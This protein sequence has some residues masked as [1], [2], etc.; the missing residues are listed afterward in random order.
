[1]GIDGVWVGYEGTRSGYAKQAGR[2]Y[3]ELFTELREH[4]IAGVV[5]H[6]TAVG[7]NTL[8]Y[9]VEAG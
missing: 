8:G 4:G 6:R 7:A 9:L 1:M 3:D 5:A 2:T